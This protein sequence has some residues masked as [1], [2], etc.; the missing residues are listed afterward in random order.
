MGKPRPG[1][2]TFLIMV[3]PLPGKYDFLPLRPNPASHAPHCTHTVTGLPAP[4]NPPH[5]LPSQP[6]SPHTRRPHTSRATARALPQPGEFYRPVE[7]CGA[8]RGLISIRPRPGQ[9]ATAPPHSPPLPASPGSTRTPSPCPQLRSR[10][11]LSAEA[12]PLPP[13]PRL[14]PLLAGLLRLL[15]STLICFPLV[16]P[17]HAAPATPPA[18]VVAPTRRSAPGRLRPPERNTREDVPQPEK[19]PHTSLALSLALSLPR[20]RFE[21]DTVRWLHLRGSAAKPVPPHQDWTPARGGT[22]RLAA[23]GARTHTCRLRTAACLLLYRCVRGAGRGGAGPRR[24][25]VD[26]RAGAHQDARVEAG[27]G[28]RKPDLSSLRPSPHCQRSQQGLVGFR[29]PHSASA[30][31]S[32]PPARFPLEEISASKVPLPW[33]KARSGKPS[34]T[35]SEETSPGAISW[36]C[37]S[38]SGF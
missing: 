16:F 35:Y 17:L 24:P 5:P 34:S 30:V 3:S 25:L 6:S 38:R 9:D 31:P 23:R 18:P 33:G 32:S 4:Q 29:A 27:A 19:R 13:A 20:A 21:G 28:P 26:A 7:F 15:P 2:T 14:L 22:E 1:K 10:R 11:D 37:P 12:S 36:S 8:H